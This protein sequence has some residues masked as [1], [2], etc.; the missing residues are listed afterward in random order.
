M[1]ESEV[2]ETSRIRVA[3]YS[4]LSIVYMV[5]HKTPVTILKLNI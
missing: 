1:V 3:V 5:K 2:I 4:E